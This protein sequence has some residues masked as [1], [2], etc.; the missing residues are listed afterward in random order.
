MARDIYMGVKALS[1][2]SYKVVNAP[3]YTQ[4]VGGVLH[5]DGGNQQGLTCAHLHKARENERESL[6]KDYVQRIFK[7]DIRVKGKANKS[8]I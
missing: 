1:K 3:A 4:I 8:E 2:S 7:Q 6:G 5:V